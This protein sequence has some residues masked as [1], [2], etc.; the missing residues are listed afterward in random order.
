MALL[1]SS[2]ASIRCSN[3]VRISVTACRKRPSAYLDAFA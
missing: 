1:I 3:G 2:D